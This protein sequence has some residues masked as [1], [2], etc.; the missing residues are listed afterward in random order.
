MVP[1]VMELGVV[2]MA[3]GLPLAPL[4]DAALTSLPAIGVLV[5]GGVASAIPVNRYFCQLVRAPAWAFHGRA[6]AGVA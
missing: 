3:N 1:P 4:T 2:L 5:G 6:F